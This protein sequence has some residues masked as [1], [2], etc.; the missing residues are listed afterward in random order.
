[1]I[2]VVFIY[3]IGASVHGELTLWREK[4]LTVI[5]PFIAIGFALLVVGALVHWCFQAFVS[6]AHD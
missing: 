4:S 1:M 6:F 2:F 3:L 5:W